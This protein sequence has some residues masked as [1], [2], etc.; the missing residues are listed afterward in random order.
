MPNSRYDK[1]LEK[2][3][4]E[5]RLTNGFK[6]VYPIPEIGMDFNG[7]ESIMDIPVHLPNAH[8]WRNSSR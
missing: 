1:T 6:T 3:I 5:Q 4:S 7:V 2:M 8:V